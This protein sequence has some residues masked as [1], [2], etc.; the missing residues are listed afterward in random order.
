MVVDFPLPDSR[1]RSKLWRIHLPVK[2]PRE[3]GLNLNII[4]KQLVFTGRQ[5]R[6]T[7]LYA[8]ILAAGDSSPIGWKHIAKAAA[9][10]MSKTETEHPEVQL[11]KLRQYLV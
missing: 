5:I 11:G 6:D 2:A 4:G 8:A 3:K 10:E 1:A 9:R 7:A